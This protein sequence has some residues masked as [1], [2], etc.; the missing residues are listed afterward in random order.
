M[1][2]PSRFVVAFVTAGLLASCPAAA[3]PQAP[4]PAPARPAAP[5]APATIA[6]ALT[7]LQKVR[8]QG[9]LQCG[10]TA[11]PGLARSDANNN[12][13]G[14]EVEVCRAVAIAV[15]GSSARFAYHQYES[16]K[17]FDAAREGS[18]QISFLTFAEMSERKLTDTLLPGPTVFVETHDLIVARGS[19]TR[20]ATEL[21]GQ[22]LCFIIGTALENSEEAFFLERHIPVVPFAFQEDGEMYD[23][24]NVQRCQAVVGESTTLASVRLDGGIN[25]LKSRFLPEHL[26]AFPIV[27][28]TPLK[29]DALWAAIVAWTI[30][31]LINANAT[32]TTYRPS[33]LNAMGV[34]GA[35][36]G[37]AKDWQKAVVKTVGSYAAIFDR[38]LGAGSPLKLEPG[39]N[40]RFV[41]GGILLPPHRD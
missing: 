24:Y 9:F 14:L 25:R 6:P 8:A 40:A 1:R 3:A 37:L 19:P 12:W 27:A 30:D 41:D 17:D 35:G 2:K 23:A 33:G 13:S 4:A 29:D 28:A 34:D 26:A 38:T 15:F 31:T 21:G 18:D 11:R 7:T 36:L 22:G 10:S 32:E 16:D 5:P 39:L 20:H